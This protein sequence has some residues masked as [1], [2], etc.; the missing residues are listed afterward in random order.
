MRCLTFHSLGRPAAFKLH[1]FARLQNG[2]KFR[3]RLLQAWRRWRCRL[4]RSNLI[5]DICIVVQCLGDHQSR[6][7]SREVRRATIDSPEVWQAAGDIEHTGCLQHFWAIVRGCCPVSRKSSTV[8]ER[9]AVRY[10]LQQNAAFKEGSASSNQLGKTED[11]GFCVA[12]KREQQRL[13]HAWSLAA[14]FLRRQNCA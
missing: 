9:I 13:L 6:T 5:L 11:Q 12:D 8:Q 2:S 4:P 10:K 7:V 1:V 14:R 3:V